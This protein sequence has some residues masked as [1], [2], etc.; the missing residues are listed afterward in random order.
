MPVDQNYRLLIKTLRSTLQMKSLFIETAHPARRFLLV[1][2][3]IKPPFRDEFYT[4][5]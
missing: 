2:S 1:V 4:S 3:K 5:R